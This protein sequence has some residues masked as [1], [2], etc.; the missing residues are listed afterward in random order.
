MSAVPCGAPICMV[1][2]KEGNIYVE[3]LGFR[4]LGFRV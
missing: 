3:G 2:S 4:V 1:S